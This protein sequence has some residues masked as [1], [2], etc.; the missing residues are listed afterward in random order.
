MF[1]SFLTELTLRFSDPSPRG[2]RSRISDVQ[3]NQLYNLFDV[4][5]LSSMGEG[6]GLPILESLAAGVPVIATDYSACQEL[7]RGHG[8]LAKVQTFLTMGTNLIEQAVVD[9]D[10]LASCIIRLY[11]DKDRMAGYREAGLRFAATLN[12][13]KLI[14]SWVQILTTFRGVPGS[15]RSKG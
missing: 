13:A 8:E 15:H 3:L 4:T 9:V 6:F 14:P 2:S 5:A 7:V 12:W 1:T 11:Q 10:D